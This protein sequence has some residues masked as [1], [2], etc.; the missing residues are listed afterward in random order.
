L[1]IAEGAHFYGKSSMSIIETNNGENKEWWIFL[2]D[3]YA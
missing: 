2:E 3:T 1:T